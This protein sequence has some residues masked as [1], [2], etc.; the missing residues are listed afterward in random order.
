MD[1]SGIFV[2]HK[3]KHCLRVGLIM[4]GPAMQLLLTFSIKVRSV[5]LRSR[6]FFQTR[7]LLTGVSETMPDVPTNL[8]NT[9]GWYREY[10]RHYHLPECV[11]YCDSVFKRPSFTLA[12][13]P[14][15]SASMLLPVKQLSLVTCCLIN[16]WSTNC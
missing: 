11:R 7:L 6:T 10:K 1:G 14:S 15:W 2:I 12:H 5:L 3:A 8:H 9:A 13:E 4:Y 16:E